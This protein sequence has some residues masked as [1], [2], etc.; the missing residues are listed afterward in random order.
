VIFYFTEALGEEAL[1]PVADSFT[2][3]LSKLHD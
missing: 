2:D 3:F 1:Y